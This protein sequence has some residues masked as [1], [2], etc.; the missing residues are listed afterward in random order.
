MQDTPEA[1]RARALE[2]AGYSR[3]TAGPLRRECAVLAL[4]FA[5][6]AEVLEKRSAAS[7]RDGAA[8]GPERA[9]SRVA[10]ARSIMLRERARQ[11]RE[12]NAE[13]MERAT[14]LGI[15]LTAK[16]KASPK[17]D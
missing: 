9:D 14:R 10:V 13:L 15:D 7:Q 16:V 11:L 17:I 6:V 2:L 3:T 12:K 5:Q 8:A 1:L 4:E